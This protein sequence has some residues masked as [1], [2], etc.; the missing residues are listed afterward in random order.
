MLSA[1]CLAGL[2][3]CIVIQ[4]H[5]TALHSSP[6]E[7]LVFELPT[8]LFIVSSHLISLTRVFAHNRYQTVHCIYIGNPS[9]SLSLSLFNPS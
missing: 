1:A 7:P 3:H 6:N 8:P 5:C 9:L 2:L 4:L